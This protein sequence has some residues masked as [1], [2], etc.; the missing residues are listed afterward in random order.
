MKI[1][2]ILSTFILISSY[3]YSCPDLSGEYKRAD[4]GACTML[5]VKDMRS[6][7]VFPFSIKDKQDSYISDGQVFSIQQ[8]NCTELTFSY[9]GHGKLEQKLVDLNVGRV[10]IKNNKIVSKEVTAKKICYFGCSAFVGRDKVSIKKEVDQSIT[11][12]TSYYDIGAY[13]Y[14]IPTADLDKVN[15]NFQKVN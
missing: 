7:P 11:I 3:A 15:C 10:K 2:Y 8:R 13:M 5:G 4:S 9:Q 1:N 12:K 6:T 14:F